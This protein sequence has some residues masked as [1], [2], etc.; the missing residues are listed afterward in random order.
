MSTISS[1][2]G[3]L[4]TAR[5]RALDPLAPKIRFGIER[6][7]V[8]IGVSGEC[9]AARMHNLRT[10][11]PDERAETGWRGAH[12]AFDYLGVPVDFGSNIAEARAGEPLSRIRGALGK[13]IPDGPYFHRS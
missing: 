8:G 6:P 9:S 12:L 4:T 1:E 3:A 10:A 13:P 11:E 5:L 2:Q 7:Q